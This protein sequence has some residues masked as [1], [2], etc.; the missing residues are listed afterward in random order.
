MSIVLK[1][2]KKCLNKN[3]DLQSLLR[4]ALLI[5]VKLKLND[6]KE[7]INCELK[8]YKESI[9]VPEYREVK[10]TLKF[11]NPYQG[12]ITAQVS[13]DLEE[14]IGF[15][16]IQQPIG[17][18]EHLIQKNDDNLSIHP[19]AEIA[20]ML[21]K[22]F[23]TDFQVGFSVNKTQIFGITEQVRNLLLEWT[24]K[25]EDDGILGN[26]DLIFTEKEKEAAQSIH[27]QNFHGVL[28]N[29]HKLGI[30]STGENSTNIYNENNIN[31]EIDKLITEIKKLN[32]KDEEQIIS[33]LEASREDTEK[34]KTILGSL[35]SRGS[36]VS[37]ISS[38]IIDLLNYIK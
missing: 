18:I 11:L 1:L 6:F 8:G 16:K 36:E 12:W 26:D 29:I 14:T 4:E 5:S 27:V 37:S 24:L 13:A 7:W 22:L 20:N 32:L 9:D 15:I 38:T 28:G 31:N 21:K 10:Q 30:M 19:P 25:L 23:N 3:E 34:T 2:Q 35:L 17:E 33:N